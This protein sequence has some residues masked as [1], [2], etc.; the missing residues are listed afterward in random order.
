L[1][2]DV[3]GGKEAGEDPARDHGRL[4]AASRATQGF[5][6]Q[7]KEGSGRVPAAVGPPVQDPHRS[8]DRPRRRQPLNH[9]SSRV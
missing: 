9:V 2:L 5:L 6:R 3:A 8:G 4:Q 7:D 1:L